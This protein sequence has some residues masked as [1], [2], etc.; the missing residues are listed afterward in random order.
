[1]PGKWVRYFGIGWNCFMYSSFVHQNIDFIY[2]AIYFQFFELQSTAL[3]YGSY[4]YY[5]L[6]GDKLQFHDLLFDDVMPL[7]L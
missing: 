7:A 4:S 2:F 5:S 3:A 6:S 1:V